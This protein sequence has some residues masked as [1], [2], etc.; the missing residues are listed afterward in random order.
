MHTFPFLAMILREPYINM[1]ELQ[2]FGIASSV[3]SS[4]KGLPALVVMAMGLV[5]SRCRDIVYRW[6]CRGGRSIT[7]YLSK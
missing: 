1:S 2:F 5:A 7:V 3:R 6:R 4:S